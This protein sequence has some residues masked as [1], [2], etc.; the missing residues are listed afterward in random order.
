MRVFGYSDTPPPQSNCAVAPE[1]RICIGLLVC[2][3]T[4]KFLPDAPTSFTNILSW[5][6]GVVFV[7]KVSANGSCHIDGGDE[8]ENTGNYECCSKTVIHHDALAAV[9][10]ERAK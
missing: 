6:Q 8:A 5:G 9:R 1:E 10:K 3:F 7:P 2:F 4:D